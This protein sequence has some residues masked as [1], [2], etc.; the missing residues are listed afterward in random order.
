[1]LENA[2]GFAFALLVAAGASACAGTAGNN[3]AAAGPARDVA[4]APVT[5]DAS[6]ALLE[7]HRYHHHGGVTLF[8][9]MS[10]D[11]LGVSAERRERVEKIRVDLH[12]RMQPALTAEQNLV[13][14][15]ADGLSHSNLDQGKVDAAVAQVAS[16]AALVRDAS[17]DALNE[18]HAALT[19]SERAALVQKVEAHWAVWQRSNAEES[20]PEQADDGHL[21]ALTRD[22]QLS[23]E[24][25][26]TARANLDAGLK[27]VPRV[28]P[29]QVAAQLAAFGTAFQNE[30]FNAKGTGAAANVENV[31]ARLA[32][33]GAAYLA[34]LVEAVAPVLLPQQRDQLAHRL[35]QHAAHNPSAEVGG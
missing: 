34:H 15:L 20:S 33:W 14:A 11:T 28:D 19:P 29:K 9:A 35:Q 10:L 4:P 22:L 26:S 32:T 16:A 5:D 7:H 31:D 21:A 3:A 30:T 6:D 18:L 27:A 8:I 12:Q 25:R 23:P 2:H 13:Q 1:M 17:A 24:Q